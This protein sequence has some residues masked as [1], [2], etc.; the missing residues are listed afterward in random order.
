MQPPY[1]SAGDPLY[2]VA[3]SPAPAPNRAGTV[4]T[5]AINEAW[6][7][8]KPNLATWIGVALVYLL[9]VGALNFVQGML[10][11]HDGQ[12]IPRQNPFSLF[13]L[14]LAS[15]ASLFL[16]AGLFK[17]ALTQL[18]TGR[19]EFGELFN[20]FD[21]A[22]PLFI[23]AVLT[24]LVTSLGF[25]LCVIPGVIA[26]L[27]LSMINPLII[28]QKVDAIVAMKRSWEV[29]KD[30]LSSL[31]VLGLVLSLIVTVS[32]CFCGLGVLI[33]LPLLYMTMAIVYRDLF[34]GGSFGVAASMPDFPTPPIANP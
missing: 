13:F 11:T 7:T 12:G 9:I 15:A 2:P 5:A 18:R 34:M 32:L 21:V 27:G 31:F 6:E 20:I 19:A 14:F 4:S 22:A 26:S 30:H 16:S 3:P 8:I 10:Q 23:A 1:P 33:T 17:V 28:D 24:T 25:V 29:C